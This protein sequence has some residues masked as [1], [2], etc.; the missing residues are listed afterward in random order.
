MD[1]E[2]SSMRLEIL[3]AQKKFED[4]ANIVS[5]VLTGMHRLYFYHK[6]SETIDAQRRFNELWERHDM[7]GI[8]LLHDE[9][10]EMLEASTKEE[11]RDEY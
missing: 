9:V 11:D 3:E 4:E 1:N 5:K 7:E 10:K 8:K 6:I 2:M